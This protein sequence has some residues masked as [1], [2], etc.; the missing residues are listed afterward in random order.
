MERSLFHFVSPHLNADTAAQCKLRMVMGAEGV[1]LMVTHRSG[2]V[3]A[4]KCWQFPTDAGQRSANTDGNLAR[5][6][7]QEDMLNWAFEQ[8]VFAVNHAHVA[9]VPRRYFRP[10]HLAEYFRL[11]LPASAST[12]FDYE[13]LPDLDCHLAWAADSGFLSI[14]KTFARQAQLSHTSAALLRYWQSEAHPTDYSAF[15]H[16][17]HQQLTVGIFDRKQLAFFNT[18]DTPKGSDVL[19]FTLLPYDQQ[20]LNPAQIPIVLSGHIVED[21]EAYRL[22]SRYFR[23]IRFLPLPPTVRIAADAGGELPAH[24]WIEAATL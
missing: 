6:L 22:L 12:R 24:F 15:A 9:L 5:V 3:M 11:L 13:P 18:F 20:R 1:S 8:S 21:S 2:E 4:L 23:Q 19:Y 16:L 10:D 7:G 17:R 14:C